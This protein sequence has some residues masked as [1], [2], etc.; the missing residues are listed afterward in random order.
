MTQFYVDKILAHRQSKEGAEV[1]VKWDGYDD[2]DDNT[3]ELLRDKINE[4]PLVVD[5]YFN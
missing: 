5:F 2:P 4:C 1:L 3:W